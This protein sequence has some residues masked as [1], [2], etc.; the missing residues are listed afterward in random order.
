M[1]SLMGNRFVPVVLFILSAVAVS[2]FSPSKSWPASAVPPTNR[3]GDAPSH[4]EQGEA[5]LRHGNL[6]GAADAARRAMEL[7]PSSAEGHYLLGRVFLKDR[8]L[9]K[10]AE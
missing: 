5:L 9:E 4:L 6:K 7:N 8:K 10:A 2:C 3:K 1:R